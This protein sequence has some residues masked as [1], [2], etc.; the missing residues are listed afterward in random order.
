MSDSESK[1]AMKINALP[2]SVKTPML[3]ATNYAVWSLRMKVLFRFHEVWETID[4]GSKDQKKNDLATI[5]LFQGIPE[6]LIL[7]VGEQDSPKGMWE[8]LKAMNIGADRVIEARLHT[9][10]I[11]FDHLRMK[12]TDS[13]DTFSGKLSEFAGTAASLG[14]TI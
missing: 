1:P 13:I 3:T 10:M 5:L 12:D 11:E 4:P 2:P 14:H 9:L 8:A 7:Q 6:N